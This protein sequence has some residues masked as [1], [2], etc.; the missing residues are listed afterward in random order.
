MLR[1][2]NA[3]RQN[4][5]E[6]RKRWFSSA[7]MDLVTWFD[8]DEVLV[9][10]QLCYDKSHAER[11]VIWRRRGT[12]LE[13]LAV[14][15]GESTPGKHKASPILTAGRRLSL[16]RVREKLLLE[17]SE[18]PPV[19]LADVLARLDAGEAIDKEDL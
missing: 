6:P 3:V 18:L 19:I 15:D 8:D 12:G 5:D 4:P 10:F 11:A 16:Q 1:E 9:A 14:D 2:I 13:H 17:S 7:S